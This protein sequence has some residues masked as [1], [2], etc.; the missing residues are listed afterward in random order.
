MNKLSSTDKR[1]G[2]SFLLFLLIVPVILVTQNDNDAA[3]RD[4]TAMRDAISKD[5]KALIV[6]LHSEDA[7]TRQR[8]A[9]DLGRNKQRGA[10]A[11]GKLKQLMR[12][13]LDPAVQLASA[14]AVALIEGN[15]ENALPALKQQLQNNIEKA[16]QLQQQVEDNTSDSSLDALFETLGLVEKIVNVIGSIGASAAGAAADLI[17]ILEKDLGHGYRDLVPSIARALESIGPAAKTVLPALE[18][19][20]KSER[21]KQNRNVINAAIDSIKGKPRKTPPSKPLTNVD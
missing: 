10:P 1:A 3:T 17:G 2:L 21:G 4:D 20:A 14:E 9:F 19:Y 6:L 7:H 15:G 8:A 13:D 18:D 16:S 5:I 12:K 11:L